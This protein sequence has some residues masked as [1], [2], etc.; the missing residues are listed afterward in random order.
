MKYVDEKLQ[1]TE[2]TLEKAQEGIV[3]KKEIEKMIE[4]K[5]SK[6]QATELRQR[7]NELNIKLGPLI[8]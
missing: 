6:I 7:I 2:E 3:R 1:S 8:E 5:A 4:P